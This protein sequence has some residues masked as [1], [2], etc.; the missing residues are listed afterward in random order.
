MQLVFATCKIDVVQMFPWVLFVETVLIFIGYRFKRV[1]RD[2]ELT[3]P[4]ADA[5]RHRCT[6]GTVCKIRR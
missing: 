2:C 5:H 3:Q 1:L 4:H 6:K